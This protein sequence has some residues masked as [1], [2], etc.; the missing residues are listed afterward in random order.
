MERGRHAT[1][2]AAQYKH[3]VLGLIFVKYVSDA[4]K[5][6]QDEIKADIANPEL[7]YYLD[8]A[9]CSEEELAE[10]IAIELEQRDFYTEKNVF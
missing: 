7:E 10:E 5:L 2:N 4:F 3:A 9:D 8:P 1:L 6:R